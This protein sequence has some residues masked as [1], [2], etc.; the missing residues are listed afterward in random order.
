[1]TGIEKRESNLKPFRKGEDRA[2]QSPGRPKTVDFA[3]A[4]REFASLPARQ[5]SLF[6]ALLKKKPDIAMAHLAGKPTETQVQ[7]V[8][9]M[10]QAETEKAVARVLALGGIQSPNETPLPT[11]KT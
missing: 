3:A 1:M 10:R 5:Q 7:L 6:K 4:F 8:G 9:E 11:Q 2:R